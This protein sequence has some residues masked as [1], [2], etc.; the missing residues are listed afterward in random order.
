MT[1][2]IESFVF[3]LLQAL[4]RTLSPSITDGK[5]VKGAQ[6]TSGSPLSYITHVLREAR[7]GLMVQGGVA[8]VWDY[9]QLTSAQ[10]CSCE[11][12]PVCR[13][14]RPIV[15]WTDWQRRALDDGGDLEE[16][17]PV[18]LLPCTRSSL[19]QGQPG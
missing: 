3:L 14:A 11:I 9:C 12:L 1:L 19:L 7:V 4:L 18:F 6:A 16:V 15:S 10:M 5:E 8:S 17:S 2:R 13:R